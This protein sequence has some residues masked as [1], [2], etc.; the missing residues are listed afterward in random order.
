MIDLGTWLIPF[1][2]ISRE[3]GVHDCVTFP[4]A[5]AIANDWADP[6]A[7]WRGAYDTEERAMELI[8]DAGGLAI[9]C[10]AGMAQAG[11]PER[12]G[13]PVSGDIGVLT[14]GGHEAGAIFTGRRWALVA[15][16]GLAFASVDPDCV[17]RK[18]SVRHG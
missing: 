10:D 5:W 11:I 17:L 1:G 16:C 6:M 4:A 8:R 3:A 15:E 9:I 13:E 14:L 7:E 18:W 12:Y 2:A